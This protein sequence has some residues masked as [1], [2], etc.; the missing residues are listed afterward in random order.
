MLKRILWIS[1]LM[2]ASSTIA[3]GKMPCERLTSLKLQNMTI[4]GAVAMPKGPYLP[5]GLP[6]DAAQY[7]K[8]QIPAY[9]RVA[10]VLTPTADSH[11]EIELWMPAR[12]SWTF[13]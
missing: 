12:E 5:Q 13:S 1:L 9:C 4:A 3:L 8:V 7:A 10:A 2:F 6:S 11:I